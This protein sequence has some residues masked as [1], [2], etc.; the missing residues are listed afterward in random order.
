MDFLKNCKSNVQVTDG[1]K[2]LECHVYNANNE[3]DVQGSVATL[4][5]QGALCASSKQQVW[6]FGQLDNNVQTTL[7]NKTEV[8]RQ[9]QNDTL[10][11]LT[12]KAGLAGHD[13][14]SILFDAI[15]GAVSSTLY[16]A[17]G[18]MRIGPF[19]WL[20]PTGP[21]EASVVLRLHLYLTESG[22]LYATTTTGSE[23]L[24]P[25]TENHTSRHSDVLLAPSGVH[26]TPVLD[27]DS[28]PVLS[29]AGWRGAVKDML[30]VE[31]ILVQDDTTWL[32]VK[33]QGPTSAEDQIF[34]WPATMCFGRT[35]KAKSRA[36][37]GSWKSWFAA[38]DD[39]DGFSYPLAD[40]EEWFKGAES[41]LQAA[42]ENS[43]VR[44]SLA[45][46]QRDHVDAPQGAS[47]IAEN[48]I[49]L[50]APFNQRVVDQQASMAGI[51]PTPEDNL[52]PGHTNHQ[53][54]SDNNALATI[55]EQ[56]DRQDAGEND[57]AGDTGNQARLS[58][59]SS[60]PMAFAQHNDDLFGDMGGM[61]FGGDEVDDADFDFF[62]EQDEMPTVS[63]VPVIDED[64]EMSELRPD[65]DELAIG[66]ADIG[67]SL[68]EPASAAKTPEK[69][70]SDQA[71]PSVPDS[72]TNFDQNIRLNEYETPVPDSA[73]ERPLSPFGIKER[74]LPPPVPASANL[75]RDREGEHRRSSFGPILFRDGLD[76]GR[77][78]SDAYGPSNLKLG[79][80]VTPQKSAPYIGLPR[81]RMDLASTEDAAG[82]VDSESES[83]SDESDVS[84]HRLPP[85]LPWNPKKRRDRKSVV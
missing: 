2:T 5:G 80:H 43:T 75:K 12:L 60:D 58:S 23:S 63:D 30:R 29:G 42:E 69:A 40:A 74:L 56:K 72:G 17:C 55:P 34:T 84:D 50:T 49:G 73:V 3:G 62:N 68:Q 71:H 10:D 35:V 44:D 1:L 83:S 77:K 7:A 70:D 81:K 22:T 38:S 67:P 28:S 51:Y 24:T 14:R 11:S 18:S 48:N 9:E 21:G 26:V 31:G 4:R 57:L 85:Q 52:M 66:N 20:L 65:N 15:Q 46:A 13:V 37:E 25:L 47:T 27:T 59:S 79:A 78:Y 39:P 16:T 76:L 54:N 33:L 45:E 6:I 82:D 32:P 8:L 64:A 36:C 61:E 53:P 19:S 41:R